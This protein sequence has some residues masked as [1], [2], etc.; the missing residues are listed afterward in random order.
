ME[1][2]KRH[3]IN[4]VKKYPRYVIYKSPFRDENTPSFSVNPAK[5]L[6]YDHGIGKGGSIIDLCMEM[7][8]FS[9]NQAIAF[10]DEK[11]IDNAETYQNSFFASQNSENSNAEMTISNVLSLEH[12][13]LIQFL[14]SRKINTNIA[15]FFCREIH[16]QVKRKNYFAIGFKN[17]LD[18]FALRNK[19]FKGCVA[20]NYITT[21]NRQTATV[22]LFEGFM[23]YLSL[24]TLQ[25]GQAYVSAVVL[26]STVN[27]EKAIPFLTKHEKI[28]AFLDNDEAGQQALGK[29]QNLKLPVVDISKRYAEYKDVND[30]LCGKK[31][32]KFQKKETIKIEIQKPKIGKRFKR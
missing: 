30:Y 19:I 20:P 2:L 15:N 28:N 32:P 18:G 17:D 13:A 1:Y 6:W 9:K 21:F 3:G 11:V 31:L 12:P 29:L 24:L 5:N 7:H 8:N 25:A 10:L 23:D 26:N 27:L 14:E 22:H 4:P 16:F